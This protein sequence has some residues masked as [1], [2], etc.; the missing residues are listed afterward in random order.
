MARR[1]GREIVKAGRCP[2]FDELTIDVPAA[3][4][5]ESGTLRLVF[6]NDRLE[7][8]FFT[9]HDFT[10]YADALQRDGRIVDRIP[11]ATV[12]WSS[13]RTDAG[14]QFVGWRDERF[15]AQVNS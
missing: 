13:N 10:K 15:D 3:D 5:G 1:L 14:D 9:P 6:I 4:L 2:R 12:V 7:T 11:P 8:T